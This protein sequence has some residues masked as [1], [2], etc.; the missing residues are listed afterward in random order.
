MKFA[1]SFSNIAPRDGVT[2]WSQMAQGMVQMAPEIEDLGFDGIHVLE[3]HFQRD[4]WNP[5]PLMFLAALSSVTRRVRLATDILLATLYNPVK[6]AEDVAVL[7]N[8]S[9][10]RVTLGIAPGYVTE[11]FEG[12]MVPFEGRARRFE[13][14]VDILQA[15]WTQETFSYEGEFFTVPPTS[16]MPRPLQSPHP[17][18]WYGVSG[19]VMM[20]RAARRGAVLVGSPRHTVPELVEHYATFAGA[21]EEVGCAVTDR[22]I[23]RGLFIAPTREEAVDIAGPGVTHLFRELYGRKSAEGARVLRSDDGSIVTDASTVDFEKFQ[24]RYIIGSPEDAIQ[25]I[26]QLRDEVG[27]TELVAWTQM[28]FVTSEQTMCSA[29]LLAGEVMPHFR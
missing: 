25:R 24:E 16:L 29:R 13:E 15:A 4:G 12:L 11:E 19:P 2:S 8:I 27:M 22:P 17:P 6:L 7:D 20:Q 10:G 21:C 9:G 14:V 26:A 5:S 3:H 23:G 18:I 1:M 28:P